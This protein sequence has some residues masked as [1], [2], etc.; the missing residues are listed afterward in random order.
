LCGEQIRYF[1]HSLGWARTGV[2]G[3]QFRD[4]GVR[5]DGEQDCE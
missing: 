2:D 3:E 5:R 4:K 1:K